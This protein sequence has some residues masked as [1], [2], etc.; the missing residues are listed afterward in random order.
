MS[1]KC[2]SQI[3][4]I[5]KVVEYELH[6]HFVAHQLSNS[7]LIHLA[8]VVIVKGLLDLPSVLFKQGVFKAVSVIEVKRDLEESKYGNVASYFGQAAEY[9]DRCDRRNVEGI[10]VVVVFDKETHTV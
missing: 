6:K 9:S 1:G 10:V 4:L 2:D 5:L 3:L 7:L 8:L